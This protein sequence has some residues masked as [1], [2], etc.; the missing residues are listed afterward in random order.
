MG[1]LF[2]Y[3]KVINF[4]TKSQFLFQFNR[5]IPNSINN[6]NDILN[7]SSNSDNN[8]NTQKIEKK[9]YNY[10][11]QNLKE[12]LNSEKGKYKFLFHDISQNTTIIIEKKIEI[13]KSLEGLS[14]L[15]LDEVLYL[16]GNCRLEDNEGS[17]LFQ[18]NPINPKTNI[19]VNSIYGHYYPSL[20]SS[21]NKYIFCIGG[22]N[23]I[24][25][26][27]YNIEKNNWNILPKLPEERYKCTLGLDTNNNSI[28]LFGGINSSKYNTE[29]KIYIENDSI[30][31]LKKEMYMKW[32]K[33]EI[34]NNIE[35]K[36][37]KRISAGSL[38]FDDQKDNI[39]ILGGENEEK[40]Y[41]DDIIKFNIN[42]NNIMKTNQKLP[43]PTIFFNQYAK[44]YE[45]NSYMFAFIDKFNN[46]I[47]I[48]KHD[49]IE[50]SYDQLEI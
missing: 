29:N 44:K 22:K 14:E 5:F 23:Q 27:Y 28:Y 7:I 10:K 36:L 6:N 9:I 2:C 19:L 1:E 4:P 42:S 37:L 17:F 46:V 3:R 18:F 20:I 50:W 12:N 35:K 33:I 40:Q 38:I 24:H 39:Y 15:N 49:F 43:F 26:E 16:C 11:G 8:N 41:L 47:K 32:E 30:L 34:K 45:N 48:D 21:E 31:R 25:C 13:V